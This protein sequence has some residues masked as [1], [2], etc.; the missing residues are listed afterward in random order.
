MRGRVEF[1][2]GKARAASAAITPEGIDPLWASWDADLLVRAFS[3][4]NSLRHAAFDHTNAASYQ[5]QTAL[6]RSYDNAEFFCL[7][8]ADPS[9]RAAAL[10]A[11]YQ[12]GR[13]T[14]PLEREGITTEGLDLQ[15]EAELAFEAAHR[16]MLKQ[17]RR[18][19]EASQIP[20]EGQTAR[21]PR[22]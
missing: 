16:Q 13:V 20:T 5:V 11:V 17:L 19:V 4:L 10:H 6:H 12:L 9:T 7:R 14:S 1:G 22:S 8:I 15:T 21:W 18:L 2:R 3:A